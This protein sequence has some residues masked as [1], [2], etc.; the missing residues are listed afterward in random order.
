MKDSLKAETIGLLG[1]GGD[2]IEAYLAQPL[3]GGR[4]GGV[5][6]IHHMPGFDEW[7]KEVT[8]EVRCPRLPCALPEPL[9]PGGT[10]G[11]SR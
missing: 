11:V 8:R 9:Q 7:S 5:V 1:H 4:F 2:E 3:D 6:V 10:R